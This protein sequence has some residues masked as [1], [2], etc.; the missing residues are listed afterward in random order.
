[1]VRSWWGV[2]LCLHTLLTS[3]THSLHTRVRCYRSHPRGAR[4]SSPASARNGAPRWG[5]A[6]TGRA[7]CGDRHTCAERQMCCG[8][9]WRPDDDSRSR[10]WRSISTVR[11]ISRPPD[12]DASGTTPLP[13]Q[14]EAWPIPPRRRS[15]SGR[16]CPALVPPHVGQVSSA[17]AAGPGA[18]APSAAA[19]TGVVRAMSSP[20][21]G[22]ARI[23]GVSHMDILCS[24]RAS[25]RRSGCL[26]RGLGWGA[27]GRIDDV[28]DALDAPGTEA[29]VG[30]FCIS[31]FGQEVVA[32]G[33]RRQQPRMR[34]IDVAQSRRLP[35]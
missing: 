11:P 16:S 9:L 27:R 26:C 12:S 28:R 31:C 15:R 33:G 1:M 18:A 25:R 32:H 5:R 30:V 8:A 22:P 34:S 3:A 10:S 7:P 20:P 4:P 21:A 6:G 24:S 14:R 17:A 29:V 2:A 13:S 35:C 19:L 23:S